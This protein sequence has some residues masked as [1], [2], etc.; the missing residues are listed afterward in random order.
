MN[1][2][3]GSRVNL[4][5][6]GSTKGVSF[7]VYVEKGNI[8]SGEIVRNRNESSRKEKMRLINVT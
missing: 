2:E 4:L 3:L 1:V 6:K 7:S 5:K 8:N